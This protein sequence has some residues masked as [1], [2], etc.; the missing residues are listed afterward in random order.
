VKKNKSLVIYTETALRDRDDKNVA[1]SG[2]VA[3]TWIGMGSAN[4]IFKADP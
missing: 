2:T 3:N 1:K 4:G